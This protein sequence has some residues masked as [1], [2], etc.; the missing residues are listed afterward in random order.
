MANNTGAL[1]LL[2]GDDSQN[3][4]PTG[5]ILIN[6]AESKEFV[7]TKECANNPALL[8]T[9][10][11]GA[12]ASS[13]A[14]VFFAAN[15]ITDPYTQLPEGK[16]VKCIDLD[17]IAGMSAEA[18]STNTDATTIRVKHAKVSSTKVTF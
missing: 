1:S 6:N 18:A 4:Y 2:Y 13:Y 3:A 8:L 9:M 16:V 12:T 14:D 7:V 17:S 5:R 15:G 10:L 11:Y